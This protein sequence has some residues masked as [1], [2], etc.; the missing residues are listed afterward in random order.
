M[1]QNQNETVRN[2]RKPNAER[3]T[4]PAPSSR[5]YPAA[6]RFPHSAFT[7]TELLVVISIIAILATLITGAAVNALNRAKQASITLEIQQL[8]SAIEDFKN[9]NGAYPPNVFANATLSNNPEKNANAQTLLRFMKKVSQRSTEFQINLTG[10][11]PARNSTAASDNLYPI[12]DVG[13]SPAE[14]L[15]FWLQGFSQDVTRPLTGTDLELTSIDD[16]GTT[17]NNVIT[18]DS[19]EPLYEFDRGR[20]RISRFPDGRR[21]YLT[22][23]RLTAPFEVYIQLYEYLAPNSEEPFVYFDTSRETPEQVVNNWAT[24]EFFYASPTSGGNIFPLK[25][26]RANAPSTLPT[27]K[28]QFVEY[29]NPDKF[30]VLHCGLDDA[31]GD[32]SAS[33]GAGG[34]LD[35]SATNGNFI[36]NLLFPTGPFIGDIADTVGNFGTG[37]LEDAQ[38]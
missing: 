13:L 3:G 28:L 18:I 27:N 12:I 35:V 16:N 37:T 15:V 34:Q 2:S 26:M 9:K 23:Q 31:W 10:S 29:V 8:A 36:P 21:R 14:A 6:F 32:F 4:L 20:L 19:F 24:T 33:T 25:K 5:S 22:V 38:Q 7:L 11:T 17:V 1:S 30:Q